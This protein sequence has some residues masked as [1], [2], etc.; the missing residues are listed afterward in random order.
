MSML[1]SI[2][3]RNLEM[4]SFHST[5]SSS[6]MALVQRTLSAPLC[7]SSQVQYSSVALC[8]CAEVT[9]PSP[10]SAPC[11]AHLRVMKVC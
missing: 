10:L 4:K 3:C 9:R 11:H 1:L 7:V 6:S 8:V 2:A 5:K